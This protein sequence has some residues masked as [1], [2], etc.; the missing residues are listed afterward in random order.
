MQN[1][2][3]LNNFNK[4]AV[5]QT[6]FIGDVI[7]SFPLC[8]AIRQLNPNCELYFVTTP[9]SAELAERII[10]INEVLIY[11][12]RN[13]HNGFSGIMKLASELK[14]RNID[15]VLTPHRSFRSSLLSTFSGAVRK[16]SFNR[17]ALS[18]LYSKRVKYKYHDHEIFRNL[19]L[20]S[21]FKEFEDYE[22]DH[23]FTSYVNEEVVAV[24]LN[25]GRKNILMFPGSVWETKKWP[26]EH[27]KELINYFNDFNV[28]L[29]G[30]KKEF[31]LCEWIADGTNANNLAGKLPLASAID[32]IKENADLVITNDSSPTHMSFIAG[33]PVVTIYGPTSPEFG[34]YPLNG[35]SVHLDLECSPCRIHGSNKCPIGT[36]DCMKKLSPKLLFDRINEDYP[37]L[38]E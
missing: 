21:V 9:E 7:L 8:D 6:A 12:K 15:L 25:N 38:F 33:K 24:I 16:I 36:H 28:Y 29:M 18:F 14:N 35:S 30:S 22:F 4:I 13:E 27:F 2:Y 31:E 32:M 1:S 26:K 10:P 3:R 34:F 19:N 37:S 11:D 20:L 17:S 5:I 23:D